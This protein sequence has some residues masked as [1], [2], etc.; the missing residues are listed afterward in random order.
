MQL[1]RPTRLEARKVRVLSRGDERSTGRRRDG[2]AG[3][4]TRPVNPDDSRASERATA[5][6]RQDLVTDTDRL[7]WPRRTVDQ[8]HER[9]FD[10]TL[11]RVAHAQDVSV[12][13][14]E[15]LEQSVLGV[16]RVLVL[17]DEDVTEGLPPLRERVREAFERPRR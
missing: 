9:S 7:D 2:N 11:V 6:T 5:V 17:V 12:L 3:P 14:A 8:R 13:A 15:E 4:T 10:K 1:R 16:V